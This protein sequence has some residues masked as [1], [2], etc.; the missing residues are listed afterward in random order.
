MPLTEHQSKSPENAQIMASTIATRVLILSDNHGEQ[1]Q[2]ATLEHFDVAIHCGDHTEESKLHEFCSSIEMLKA[3]NAPLKLVI[4]G[5]HDFTL[6]EPMFRKKISDV[7][8]P[9]DLELVKSV[10]GDF[11]EARRLFDDAK[12]SGIMYLDE[13][14]HRICLENGALLTV[15][16]SPYTPSS[17]DWGFQYHPQQDHEWSIAPGVDVAITHGPPKGILDYTDSRVRAGSASLFAAIARARPQ[18]HCF[19]HIHEAWGAKLASWRDIPD[20]DEP[21]HFT[22]IDNNRSVVVETLAGVHPRKFDDPEMIEEK[23][24]KLEVYEQKG[25]CPVTLESGIGRGSQTLFVNAAIEGPDDSA[26]QTPWV[27]SLDLRSI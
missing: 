19:G 4:A 24:R 18:L 9:L 11:G 8:P 15:Y 5:N 17:S 3:I 12:S 21:S 14:T 25:Y 1:L 26:Q 22:A 27:V 16:A 7:E 6:D 13:G 20:G 23:K 10:Y 2:R